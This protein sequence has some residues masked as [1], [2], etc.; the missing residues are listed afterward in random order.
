MLLLVDC[1]HVCAPPPMSLERGWISQIELG[2]IFERKPQLV[3]ALAQAFHSVVAGDCVEDAALEARRGLTDASDYGIDLRCACLDAYLRLSALAVLQQES[4]TRPR[5]EKPQGL[6]PRAF[7]SR[8]SRAI[9]R[10]IKSI[11]PSR[12]SRSK[13]ITLFPFPGFLGIEVKL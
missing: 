5:Y 11:L 6:L 3:G 1:T 10:S 8:S 7:C 4:I 13:S 12:S 9:R 2:Y